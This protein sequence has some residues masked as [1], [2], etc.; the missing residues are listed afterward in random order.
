MTVT[1]PLQAHLA[2]GTVAWMHSWL[3]SF[4]L[5]LL[6]Q[7]AAQLQ[8]LSH[9]RL[10]VYLV[11]PVELVDDVRSAHKVSKRQGQLSRVLR[12]LAT[13]VIYTSMMFF[14]LAPA[15]SAI[16]DRQ[17]RPGP[18]LDLATHC[19]HPLACASHCCGTA[20]HIDH[21]GIASCAAATPVCMHG[22]TFQHLPTAHHCRPVPVGL[23][24]DAVLT[25]HPGGHVLAGHANQAW[26][27]Q[28]HSLDIT[29]WLLGP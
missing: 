20:L 12:P 15:M 26:H 23:H 29:P 9:W 16:Y 17:W 14:V 22:R 6:A 13:N 11:L 24:G 19:V 7:D 25:M 27:V 2:L 3:A 1:L 21:C 10:V 28:P 18:V 8:A 4:K 5:I